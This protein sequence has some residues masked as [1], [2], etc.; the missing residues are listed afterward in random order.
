ME[1]LIKIYVKALFIAFLVSDVVALSLSAPRMPFQSCAV[2]GA[3]APTVGEVISMGLTA[4]GSSPCTFFFLLPKR[5][6]EHILMILRSEIE[7]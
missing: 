6:F 2:H 3:T 4:W 1:V 7:S 5:K